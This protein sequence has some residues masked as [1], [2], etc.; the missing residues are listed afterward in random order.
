MDPSVIDRFDTDRWA[1]IMS[2]QGRDKRPVDA[3][4]YA[5]KQLALGKNRKE[6]H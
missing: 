4:A 6:V 5:L 3:S 2:A 1:E